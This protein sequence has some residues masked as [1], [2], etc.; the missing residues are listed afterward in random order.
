LGAITD[1]DQVIKLD[2]SKVVAY[3][4]R[5]LLKHRLNDHK[6]AITDYNQAIKIKPDYAD[7]YNYR[8]VFKY[9]LG[10]LRSALFDFQE[11]ANLYQRDGNT[12]GY[13][14]AQERIRGIAG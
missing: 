13:Q 9:H 10:D 3:L 7:A 14:I 6:N 12:Q 1:F 5:G 11:A 8:G 2:P 4:A